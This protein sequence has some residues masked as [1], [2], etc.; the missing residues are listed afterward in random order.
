M[1]AVL[2]LWLRRLK[3]T[4]QY[5]HFGVTNFLQGKGRRNNNSTAKNNCY[6]ICG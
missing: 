1:E 5:R 6:V 4:S 3:G 2:G